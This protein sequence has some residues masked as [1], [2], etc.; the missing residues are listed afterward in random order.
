MTAPCTFCSQPVI[1][2][3]YTDPPMCERHLDLA[4]IIGFMIDRGQPVTVESVTAMLRQARANGGELVID[5][6]DVAELLPAM[7]QEA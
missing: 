6:A 3:G 7:L 4:V 5:A 2:A 1:A